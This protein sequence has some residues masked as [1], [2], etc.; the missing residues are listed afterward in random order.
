MGLGLFQ[1]QQGRAAHYPEFSIGAAPS[2]LK[3]LTI[4]L[5]R[6]SIELNNCRIGQRSLLFVSL[7]AFAKLPKDEATRIIRPQFL[8]SGTSLA[9]N[10]RAA[11]RARSSADFISKITVVSEEADETLF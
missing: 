3:E 10:Y 9:A 1:L 11:C 2:G 7:K 8:R 5:W 4:E 6:H